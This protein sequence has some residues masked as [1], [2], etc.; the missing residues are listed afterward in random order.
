MAVEKA[1]G[2]LDHVEFQREPYREPERRRRPP[3][4]QAP[5][6][7][8]NRGAHAEAVRTETTDAAD[9]VTTSRQAAG[10]D[11]SMLLV[12]EF[13]SVTVDLRDHFEQRFDAI[14]VDERRE[15]ANDQ[16]QFR[17]VVQFRNEGALNRFQ[18]ELTHYQNENQATVALPYAARRDFFDALQ[19]VRPVSGDERRGKRLSAE[20]V[21][22]AK[23]FYLDVDLWHPGDEQATQFVRQQIRSLCQ[24]NGGQWR[25]AVHTNSLILGKVQAN[26][27]LCEL[28]LELD[29]A[30]RVDLPSQVG[31]AFLGI[32]RDPTP[33]DPGR[34]PDD[35]DG[36]ACVIDSGV[37]AGHPLLSNWVVEERDFDSGE[38]TAVDLNGHGT[39]VAGLVVYGDVASCIESDEWIPRVRIC[40]AKVLRHDATF[41]RVVFPEENRIE[42]VIENAVRYFHDERR[43]RVFNI[44]IGDEQDIYDGG[45][46][47]P[48]AEKLDEL[49]RE[50]DIVV[51]VAAGNRSDVPFPAGTLTRDQIQQA[52]RQQL[53]ADRLQRVCNPATASLAVTVGAIPRSDALP[54]GVALIPG[55]PR[56]APSPFTR[57]GPGYAASET[58]AAVKPDVVAYGGN[59][60]LQTL[61]GHD[62][63]WSDNVW[64]GEPTIRPEQDGRI[65]TGQ[66]GTSFA[67]PHLTHAA[68]CVEQSLRQALGRDPSANA[69][70]AVLGTA[71]CPTDFQ[72]EWIENDDD[73]LGAC[74]YG[75]LDQHRAMWSIEQNACL[76]AEDELE[77]DHLHIYRIGVPQ[78]F[79]DKK[80][81]RGIVV[82]LAYDPPVRASRRDYLA[83]TMTVELPH[84]LTEDDARPGLGA[85]AA[86]P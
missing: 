16:D 21:P 46:Q 8:A 55:S 28:L 76:L 62:P 44:S 36:L 81:R 80:G 59:S 70:R 40:S 69:I 54:N 53:L 29:L 27:T 75:V 18:E 37:V 39:S 17:C 9:V 60:G 48:L 12:L 6:R 24:N 38:N 4:G 23:S 71:V 26:S 43:C 73:R 74:G 10:V 49:A 34:M 64:L 2:D 22:D 32:F 5:P 30:A 83:R 79:R 41:D 1:A 33:P 67:A 31:D 11:P 14:V 84:G 56:G 63:R 86:G 50:L 57:V 77:E 20:G 3:Y 61:A 45:R 7:P 72:R 58:A 65:L 51:V 19:H 47:F 52:V 15:K 25:D 66:R 85:D 68:A 42:E 78:D 35:E 13:D 82:A